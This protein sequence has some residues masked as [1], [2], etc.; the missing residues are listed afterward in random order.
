MKALWIRVVRCERW[1]D[2][3]VGDMCNDRPVI[4]P[5]VTLHLAWNDFHSPALGFTTLD[6]EESSFSSI[7]ASVNNC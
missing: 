1:I 5:Q 6:V 4:A 2:V 3:E 7:M